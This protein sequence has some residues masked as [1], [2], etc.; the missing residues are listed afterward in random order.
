MASDK[1]VGEWTGKLRKYGFCLVDGCP[2]DPEKTKELLERISFIRLTH[3]GGFYD[4]TSDLTMKDTA[5]TSQAL[6]AHTDNTYFTD[7]SGLQMFHMLSHEEGTGGA[8]FFVDGFHAAQILKKTHPEA[9]KTLAETPVPWHA[10]GNEG[11][12][13]TPAKNFPVLNLHNGGSGI[14]PGTDLMQVRWNNDDRGVLPLA[15]SRT[16]SSA[17]EL[18]YQ[19]AREWDKIIRRKSMQ[20]TVQLQPGRPIIFDNWRVL[21]GRDVFTGKRRMCGGYI[22]RDDYVSRWRNTNFSRE[23]VMAQIL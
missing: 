6:G 4:F 3:Y 19:A 10:S 16:G 12:T 18:W 15:P 23:E 2:V 13:I 22:N 20:Y 1:G 17:A 21:H 7:P 8:N 11:I 5:Y 9:Y 14:Q